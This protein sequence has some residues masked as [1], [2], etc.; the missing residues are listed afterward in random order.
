VRGT[1]SICLGLALALS[2]CKY[3]AQRTLEEAADAWD[4]K[5]YQQAAS[6]YEKYLQRD[7]AS[8][9]AIQA[10]F[11]VANIYYLDLH[12]YEEARDHYSAFLNLAPSNVNAPAARERLADILADTG[13]SYQAI[14]EFE[15]LSPQDETERRRIRLRIAELYFDQKNYSQALTEY[16]KVVSGVRYDS[17]S[18]QAY[19]REASI[20][21]LSR[22]QYKLAIP[23]YRR[24]ASESSD[25]KAQARALY[26]LA[27]C[28]AGIF[29]FDQAIKSLREIQDPAEQSYASRKIADFE[30][31]AG[32][33]GRPTAGGRP[34]GKIRRG[35]EA[36]TNSSPAPQPEPGRRDKRGQE[37]AADN[38]NAAPERG[39]KSRRQRDSSNSS[40][41]ANKPENQQGPQSSSAAANQN[42]ASGRGRKSRRQRDSSNSSASANNAA[43][44]QATASSSATNQNSATGRGRRGRKQRNASDSN[45]NSNS[46]PSNRAKSPKGEVKQ[47]GGASNSNA[48]DSGGRRRG[49]KAKQNKNGAASTTQ[50]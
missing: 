25:P 27:D 6:L 21:H 16:D 14:A 20:Y 33:S 49:R 47:S 29:Q 5:N 24:L 2:S 46:A 45:S 10:H 50:Q 17:L 23:I 38:R 18:E 1:V 28:Y 30:R 11:Q 39:R 7:T 3:S 41:S 31:Q 44:Q 8:E 4:S 19:R 32:E 40:A 12:R 36:N 43:N 13:R 37:A 34:T 42:S 9:Q 22:G 48:A 35:G 26:D 15:N